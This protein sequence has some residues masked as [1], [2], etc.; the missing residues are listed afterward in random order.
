ML[1]NNWKE[2]KIIDTGDKE[3]LED[4]NGVI[5]RRPDPMAIWPKTDETLWYKAD[6]TYLRSKDG[7]GHWEY[8]KKVPEFW[9]INYQGLKFKVSPTNFKH[10]GIFP[11]QA[12]N[13]DLIMKKVKEHGNAKVLNMFAYTGCATVAASS[14]GAKEVVHVDASKGMIQWAKENVKLNHLEDNFIRFIE[15][16]CVKF[17]KREIRRGRKYDLIIMDPPSYGRGPSGEMFRFEDK[18]NELIS[19]SK[20]LMSDNP[21]GII[22][23]SYTTGYSKTVL[24]NIMNQHFRDEKGIISSDELLIPTANEDICLPCGLTTSFFYEN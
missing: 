1:S 16:D 17:L 20:E 23:N 19:L 2:Y 8:Q 3:K 12:Y 9:H 24:A 10:T 14:A 5:L 7:G 4:W 18:I 22:V 11:E 6:A 15:D 13:W 21:I